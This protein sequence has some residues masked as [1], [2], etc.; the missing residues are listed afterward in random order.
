MAGQA[1]QPESLIVD[2]ALSGQAF[3]Y[4]CWLVPLAITFDAG[5]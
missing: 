3:L 1:L 5:S 4:F 2:T